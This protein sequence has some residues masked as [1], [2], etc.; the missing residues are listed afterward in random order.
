VLRGT[1]RARGRKGH[2][3][4]E[5]PGFQGVEPFAAVKRAVQEFL[6]DDMMTYAAALAF[7]TLLALFPFLIF[8]LAL[9]GTL[10]LTGF[11]DRM[12]G[13]ARV[14]LPAEAYRI[15][16]RVIGEIRGGRGSGGLLSVSILFAVWA[17]STAVRSLMNA[18]NNAYDLA[19]ERPVWKRYLLS[20]LY[21]VGLAILVVLAAALAL[22][23]PQA[24]AWLTA[25][26]GL[27]GV[28]TSLWRWLRWPAAVVLIGLTVAIVYS[29]APNL[30]QPFRAITPGS[31]VA[32]LGWLLAS[33]GFLFY[34]DNVGTYTATYGS[35]GGVIVLLLYFFVTA[36]V[37]LFGAELNAAIYHARRRQP[38]VTLVRP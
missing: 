8:L 17:A 21:T 34:V 19:E 32:V 28:V 12:L 24:I 6:A 10:G 1:A 16:E 30:R 11:F 7:R 15:V 13:E 36:A 37:L 9:L 4:V 26:T 20:V 14:A 38:Q 33:L 22:I 23:G 27:G 2:G 5:I 18:L 35:L 3:L 31:V 25:P 29:V